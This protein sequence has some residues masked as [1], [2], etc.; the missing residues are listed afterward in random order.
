[1]CIYL[2]DEWQTQSAEHKEQ[3][4]CSLQFHLCTKA[5][6]SWYH[7]YQGSLFCI[8]PYCT[9]QREGISGVQF[10]IIQQFL[11]LQ[12]LPNRSLRWPGRFCFLL[13]FHFN[14]RFKRLER[15]IVQVQ[16]KLGRKNAPRQ[17]SVHSRKYLSKWWMYYIGLDLYLYKFLFIL[18]RKQVKLKATTW[19]KHFIKRG[20]TQ[21][22]VGHRR[23]YTIWCLACY[24]NDN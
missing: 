14:D 21:S 19:N 13:T 15:F 10:V 3:I 8:W 2:H 23:K 4:Q 24:I 18:N 17:K 7:Q 11:N 12:M 9:R 6:L 16:S 1:M 20:P 22:T 5:T